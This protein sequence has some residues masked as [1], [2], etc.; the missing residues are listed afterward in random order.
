MPEIAAAP[1][2]RKP[3]L[4]VALIAAVIV[5][6]IVIPDDLLSFEQLKA[7]RDT[8]RDAYLEQP[9]VAVALFVLTYSVTTAASLPIASLLGLGAGAVFGFWVALPA[10]SIGSTAGATL[11]FLSARYLLRDSVRARFG[12][13][14]VPIDRGIARDGARYLFAL[15]LAPVMPFWLINLG[16][17]PTSLRTWTFVWV[18]WLGMLP[19]S[20]IYVAAGTR[21]GELSSPS[22]MLSWPI[23]LSLIALGLFP[24]AA[25]RIMAALRSNHPS[26]E[27]PPETVAP[28][29]DGE[30]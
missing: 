8:L 27:T 24:L 14:L 4:L 26:P 16:L 3:A 2:W 17:A 29:V 23:V 7:R 21:I 6:A 13:R 9:V 25:R 30:S 19:G 15:R 12:A 11:A 5:V 22:D 20:A 10:V 1:R 18:S 28:E